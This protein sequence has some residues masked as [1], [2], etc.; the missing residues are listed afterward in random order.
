MLGVMANTLAI[1]VGGGVGLLLKKG[2]PERVSH[3]VMLAL[4]MCSLY[5]GIDGALV[6]E[7]TLVLIVSMVLGAMVGTAVDIDAKF[8]TLGNKLSAKLNKDGTLLAESF[9]NGS[10]LFCIGA[11]AIVGALDAGLRGDNRV[12]FTKAVIDLFSSCML[13]CSMG[14]GIVL[15]GVSVF[16]VQGLLVLLAGLLQDVLT[17]SAMVNEI[18]C[19]GN[20]LIIGIGLNLLGITKLKIANFLP[21]I[22]F[23]PF[24]YLFF[25]LLPLS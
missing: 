8:N 10:L 11:M 17:D 13:A 7:K 3:A 1:F 6:G 25:Q 20:L 14:I 5:M 21:A 16:I 2:I 15:S 9:V 22:L 4:G 18:I 23:V 12:Y 19:C 24:V